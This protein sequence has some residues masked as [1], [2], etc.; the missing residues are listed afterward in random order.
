MVLGA[1]NANTYGV[2]QGGAVYT[3]ADVAIG[4]AILKRLNRNQ[5]VFTIEMKM[6]FIKKGK[7]S[8]LHAKT[9]IIHWGRKTLVTQCQIHDDT[10]DIIAQ[11][12]GTFF[13]AED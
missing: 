10:G 9:E 3:L 5:K 8:K 12:L 6:N 7:G 2:A 1:F 13:I 11:S 4:Y